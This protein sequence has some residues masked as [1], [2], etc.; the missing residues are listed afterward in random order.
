MI[1]GAR[2]DAWTAGNRNASGTILTMAIEALFKNILRSLRLLRCHLKPFAGVF[3][4]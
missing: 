4:S 1:T 2:L 3:C